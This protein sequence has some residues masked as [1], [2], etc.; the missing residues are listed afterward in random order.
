MKKAYPIG[1][2]G[3]TAVLMYADDLVIICD[4]E[5]DLQCMIDRCSDIMISIEMEANVAKC[6]IMDMKSKNRP[7]TTTKLYW[8]GNNVEQEIDIKSEYKYLGVY[9]DDKMN[10][11]K[12]IEGIKRKAYIAFAK[13]RPYLCNRHI[14]VNM[15]VMAFNSLITPLFCYSSE[16][17]SNENRAETIKLGGIYNNLMKQCVGCVR[18]CKA[19]TIHALTYLHS[20]D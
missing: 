3:E 10:W 11:E 5:E 13:L 20:I 17:W 4:N 18:S 12:N 14:P 7:N 9:F 16:C 6:A 1:I 2:N 8:R 19:D 15:K